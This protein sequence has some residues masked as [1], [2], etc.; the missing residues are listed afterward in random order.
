MASPIIVRQLRNV[1]SPSGKS[2]VGKRLTSL[3]SNVIPK[4]EPKFANILSAPTECEM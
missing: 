1:L 2:P 4:R 3:A